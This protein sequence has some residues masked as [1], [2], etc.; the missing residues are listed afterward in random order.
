M[1]KYLEHD[2]FVDK[3]YEAVKAV[4][5]DA[6]PLIEEHLNIHFKDGKCCCPFH[7]EKTPSFSVSQDKK[8]YH[9]FGCGVSGNVFDFVRE[10]EKLSFVESVE[11]LAKKAGVQLSYS[12]GSAKSVDSSASKIKDEYKN[13][14]TRVAGMFHYMLMETPAGKFALGYILKRGLSQEILEKFKIGY[15]PSDRKWLKQFLLSGLCFFF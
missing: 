7:N 13:L 4:G 5:D 9:C 8:F 12:N 6:I 15:S 11:F 14:Y 10:M 1:Q 3:V 2:E